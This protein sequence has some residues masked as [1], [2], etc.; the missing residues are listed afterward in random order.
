MMHRPG[1]LPA[2]LISQKSEIFDSF[3]PGEAFGAVESIASGP[4]IGAQS[5][6]HTQRIQAATRP[7][8]SGVCNIK[9]V[10]GYAKCVG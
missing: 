7:P 9:W 6:T 8:V 4:G 5:N 10:V 1:L 3:P 2:F